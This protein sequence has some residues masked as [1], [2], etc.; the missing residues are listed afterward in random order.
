MFEEIYEFA[1]LFRTENIAKDNF[2][3]AEWQ[4]IKSELERLLEN[5]KDEEYLEGLE[6]DALAERLAYYL[7]ELNVLHPFREGNG[8]STREF[9]RQLALKNNYYLNFDKSDAEKILKASINSVTDIANLKD[10]IL[11]CLED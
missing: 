7:S 10:I 6:Q 1:G 9:I 8:R 3:F 4:Y 2:R 11:D 5:L